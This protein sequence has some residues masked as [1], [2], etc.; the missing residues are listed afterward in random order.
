MRGG[1]ECECPSRERGECQSVDEVHERIPPVFVWSVYAARLKNST[2]RTR[3][4][5]SWRQ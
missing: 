2:S 5:V 3:A 4:S 1:R